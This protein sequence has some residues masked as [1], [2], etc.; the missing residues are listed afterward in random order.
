MQSVASAMS[1][2]ATGSTQRF[3]GISRSRVGGVLDSVCIGVIFHSGKPS[4]FEGKLMPNPT[5]I[6]IGP[7]SYEQPG[8]KLAV[9]S[10]LKTMSFVSFANFRMIVR[11]RR[12]TAF[13]LTL[14]FARESRK[15][16]VA[17]IIRSKIR[18]NEH[19]PIEAASFRRRASAAPVLS[20]PR[21]TMGLSSPRP[22]SELAH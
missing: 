9:E 10:L 3:C 6:P 4:G 8:R 16:A 20:K 19:S 17:Q 15:S 12:T 5:S 21:A 1:K 13:R 2:A 11:Q 7:W 22:P 18:S 14:R